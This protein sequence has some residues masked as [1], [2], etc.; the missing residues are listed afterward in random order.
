VQG[1]AG[2]GKGVWGRTTDAAGIGVHGESLAGIGVQATG[3]LAP[4]RLGGNAG[5]PTTSNVP[6]TEGEVYFSNDS[7][8]MWICVADGTPGTWRKVG[9]KT[10]AG[11]LHVLPTPVRVYD[12]RPGFAPDIGPKSLL[13]G[14]VARAVDLKANLSE[15][16]AGATAAL[17]SLIAA[18]SAAAGYMAIFRNGIP[19]PGTSNVNWNHAGDQ[20]SVTTITALDANAIAAVYANVATDVIIDVLAYYL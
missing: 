5:D 13:T 17:V 11:S 4:L 18:D 15:V 19:W 20:T 6:H 9:G 3:A 10:T 7:N 16:P 12:S 8:S 14:G 1:I 2:S